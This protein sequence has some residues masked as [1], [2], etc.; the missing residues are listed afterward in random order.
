MGTRGSIH[1]DPVNCKDIIKREVAYMDEA[2]NQ[3]LLVLIS[4]K[5]EVRDD[6]RGTIYNLLY[7]NISLVEHDFQL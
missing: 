2:E 1:R 7:H 4:T 3:T 5:T 6:I